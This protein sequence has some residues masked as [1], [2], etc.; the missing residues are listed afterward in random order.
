LVAR[1]HRWGRLRLAFAQH[2]F[3]VEVDVREGG[4]HSFEMLEDRVPALDVADHRQILHLVLGRVGPSDPA[5]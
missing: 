1:F 2:R 5:Q 3:D 4:D